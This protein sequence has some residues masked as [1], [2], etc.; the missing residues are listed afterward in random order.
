MIRY[1]L[2]LT[3]LASAQAVAV[4]AQSAQP[5]GATPGSQHM[6][7]VT[8]AFPAPVAPTIRIAVLAPLYLDSA[9]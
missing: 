5:V 8:T 1:L 2:V 7:A 4:Q 3:L 6:A 9:F